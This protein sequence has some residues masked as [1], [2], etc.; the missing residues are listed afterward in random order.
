MRDIT[1]QTL[2]DFFHKYEEQGSRFQNLWAEEKLVSFP[3]LCFQGRIAMGRWPHGEVWVPCT[4]K[5]IWNRDLKT[6]RDSKRPI[7]F[8]LC[9]E[10]SPPSHQWQ[11]L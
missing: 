1:T 5:D 7:L 2:Y 3:S 4:K 11:W 6:W 10:T 9:K 8:G